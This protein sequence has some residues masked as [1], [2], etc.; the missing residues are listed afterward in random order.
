MTSERSS[1]AARLPRLV[2]MP[3]MLLDQPDGGS[4]RDRWL[5]VRVG[6]PGAEG[7]AKLAGSGGQ[8]LDSKVSALD[9]T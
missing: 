7:Q 1:N 6:A 9:P 3:A 4:H 8:H 5:D 2:A